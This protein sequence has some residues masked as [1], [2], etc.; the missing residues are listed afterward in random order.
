MIAPA[1]LDQVVAI[2]DRAG[3]SD[4]SVAALRQ[5]FPD[6]HFTYCLDDDVGAQHESVRTG[7]GFNLYLVDGREHCLRFTHDLD[8]ATGLVLAAVD[9]DADE[10]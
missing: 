7:S 6:L 10:D 1:F 4:D 5:A 8:A 3:L 9:A 2:L